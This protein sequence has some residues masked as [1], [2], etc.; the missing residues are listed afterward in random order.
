M[1]F[2]YFFEGA[3]VLMTISMIL[4]LVGCT[5]GDSGM[6]GPTSVIKGEKIQQES[7]GQEKAVQTQETAGEEDVSKEEESA[8]D[9]KAYYGHWKIVDFLAPGITALSIDEMEGYI[10]VQLTYAEDSFTVDDVRL[11]NP[12]YSETVVTKEE[13]ADDFNNQVNFDSLNI[14]GDFVTDVSISNSAAFGSMFYAADAETLYITLDG[15]F[16]K[17]ERQSE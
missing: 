6:D 11:E 4:L 17:A 9:E 12:I 15:A 13:F 2:I 10:D 1:K 3:L 8:T 14:S 5:K 16:F 7:A